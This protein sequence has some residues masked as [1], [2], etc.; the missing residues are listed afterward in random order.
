MEEGLSRS[1]GG[2][3]FFREIGASFV[4]GANDLEVMDASKVRERNHSIGI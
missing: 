4:A 2:P 1:R 3:S